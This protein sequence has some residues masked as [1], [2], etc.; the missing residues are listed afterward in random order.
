MNPSTLTTDDRNKPHLPKC[1][2]LTMMNN[3]CPK[4]NPIYCNTSTL[5]KVRL[6]NEL[7]SSSFSF[8]FTGWG[9]TVWDT[10]GA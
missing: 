5:E 2:V 9:E 3:Q 10:T 4:H 1:C 6:N 8:K 7:C